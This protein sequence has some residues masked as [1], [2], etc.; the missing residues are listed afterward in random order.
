MNRASDYGCC[1]GY[2]C[3]INTGASCDL[4]QKFR[5]NIFGVGS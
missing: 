5:G 4:T 1:G 2:A 3:D